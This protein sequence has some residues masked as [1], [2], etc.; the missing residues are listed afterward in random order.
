MTMPKKGSISVSVFVPVYNEQYFVAASLDRLKILAE[1]ELCSRIEVIVVDDGSTDRTPQ[2]L[3][4]FRR[5]EA[6]RS[7][8]GASRKLTWLFLRHEANR[9]KGAAVR[10]ALKHATGEVSVIHDADLE[11]H[12]KDI[13]RMLRVF[14]EQPADAVFGSRFAG[15]EVRRVLMYRHQLGNKFLTCLCNLMSNLNLSDVWTCYK[16]VR[17]SLLKS[18]PLCADDFRLEPELAIKLAK[19]RA[20]IFEIPIDYFGRSYEEGKKIGWKDGLRALAAIARFWMSDELYAD[21]DPGVGILARLALAPRY[22]AWV[23]DT[24]RPL[25]GERVIEVGSGL[26]R[27]ALQLV[28]RESFTA[29]DINPLCLEEPE[30]IAAGRPY[31]SAAYFDLAAAAAP[32]SAQISVDTVLCTNVLEHLDDDQGALVRPPGLP[33]TA[34]PPASSRQCRAAGYGPGFLCPA[35]CP[36]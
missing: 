22:I 20:R 33:R 18:I 5:Q 1:S 35:P 9:G 24:L 31:L 8:D 7:A 4:R 10:T 32:G 17:T 19:R 26:G 27:V 16:A 34:P 36:A 12:P 29:T 3:E 23:A 14:I 15:S 28:P 13:L 21:D 11:Y 30:R 6:L 2:V 25:C